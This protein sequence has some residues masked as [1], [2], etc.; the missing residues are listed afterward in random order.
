MSNS[1]QGHPPTLRAAGFNAVFLKLMG[2]KPFEGGP[3]D[4]P[5]G[6]LRLRSG[7]T[8]AFLI[9]ITTSETEFILI[10]AG[11]DKSAEE[12][13]SVLAYKGVDASAV[14]AILVTHGHPDHTAGISQFPDAEVYIG[15]EDQAY[16]EGKAKA[17]GILGA[18]NPELAIQDSGKIRV[19][20]DGQTLQFGDISIRAFK[21][22]GHT[23][24]SLAFVI[25]QALFIGD[26]VTFD[27][28]DRAV[29]PPRPFTHSMTQALA[30][31]KNLITQ[32]DSEAIIIRT[33]VPNHSASGSLDAIRTL[34]GMNPHP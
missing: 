16:I 17:D 13:L 4:E 15:A 30:S 27:K 26:A 34:V 11:A 8:S 7:Y 24:G 28:K 23:R 12:I 1:Q 21:V 2:V 32:L 3:I 19:V 25:G 5:A 22:P 14:K 18:K 10:D 9:P 29:K 20:T 33:V 31:L 6:A